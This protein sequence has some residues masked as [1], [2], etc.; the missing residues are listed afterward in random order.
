MTFARP[1]LL[2]LAALLPFAIAMVVWAARRRRDDL[3]R[4][5]NPGLLARLST[6]TSP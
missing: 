5:G 6:T 4:L 2:Y 3:Q 1:E